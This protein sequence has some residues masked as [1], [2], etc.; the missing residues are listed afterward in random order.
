MTTTTPTTKT[1]VGTMK[2]RALSVMPRRLTA[3]TRTRIAR[4]SCVVHGARAGIAAVRAATPA[5][6]ETATLRT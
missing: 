2:A 1:A 3:V 6:I 4:H 5:A